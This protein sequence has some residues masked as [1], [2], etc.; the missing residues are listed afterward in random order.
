VLEHISDPFAPMPSLH[1]VWSSWV[2]YVL[3]QMLRSR[4]RSVR[5]LPWIY[6]VFTGLVVIVTGTH[7]VID[8]VGGAVVFAV[9]VLAARGVDRMTGSRRTRKAARADL[10]GA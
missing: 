1:I 7:W 2:A 6:P 3:W 9:A 8:L 10:S 5:L 4:R